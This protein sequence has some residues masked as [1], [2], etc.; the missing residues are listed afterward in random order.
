M[1]FY[2]RICVKQDDFVSKKYEVAIFSPPFPLIS[3]NPMSGPESRGRPDRDSSRS[4]KTFTFTFPLSASA[5]A[6]FP[7][8]P[9]FPHW[10]LFHT[11]KGIDLDSEPTYGGV[12]FYSLFPSPISYSLM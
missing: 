11:D 3:W 2:R 7:H 12:A 1:G 4:Q 9:T 6:N 10:P 8:L 5:T